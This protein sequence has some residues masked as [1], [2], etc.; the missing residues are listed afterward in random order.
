MSDTVTQPAITDTE[1][2]EV[3]FGLTAADEKLVDVIALLCEIEEATYESNR[4]LHAAAHATLEELLPV[5]D[6]FRDARTYMDK[7]TD[8]ALDRLYPESDHGMTHEVEEAEEMMMD[9]LHRYLAK[10]YEES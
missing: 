7:F 10:R 5:L 3:Y 1:L 8:P 4:P 9:S 2:A 6:R